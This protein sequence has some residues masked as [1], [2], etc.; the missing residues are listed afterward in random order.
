MDM[1]LR[2]HPTA[3]GFAVIWSLWMVWWSAD[4]SLPNILILSVTGLCV[5]Y[6]WVWAM[7]RIQRWRQAR[8]K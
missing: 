8:G 3:I 5:G 1:L 6:S 4:Y 2:R 7:G